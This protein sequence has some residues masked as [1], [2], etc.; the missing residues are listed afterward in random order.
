MLIV[1]NTRIWREGLQ[2]W[3]E[4]KNLPELKDLL[5]SVPPLLNRNTPP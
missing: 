4:A 3:V 5:I 2:D 1:S